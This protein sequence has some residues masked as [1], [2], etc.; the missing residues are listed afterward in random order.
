MAWDN[1]NSVKRVSIL[2]GYRAGRLTP[3]VSDPACAGGTAA[4]KARESDQADILE[5]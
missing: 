1:G 2:Q 3:L 5:K 4:R